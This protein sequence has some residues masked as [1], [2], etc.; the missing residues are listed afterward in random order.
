MPTVVDNRTDQLLAAIDAHASL[1]DPLVLDCS[2]LDRVDFSAA[3][4]LM[5]GLAPLV[6]NGKTIEMHDVSRLVLALFSMIGLADIAR[7]QPRRH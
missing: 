7:I 3:G 1:H 6:R 2:R 4:Q 5:M